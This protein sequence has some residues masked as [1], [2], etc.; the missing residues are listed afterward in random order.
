M[1]VFYVK[2]ENGWTKRSRV[3]SGQLSVVSQCRVMGV[4]FWRI[5]WLAV[6][7]QILLHLDECLPEVVELVQA[8]E[9]ISSPIS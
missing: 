1:A 5:C 2:R 4:A 7:G 9:L 6:R 8:P 3:W